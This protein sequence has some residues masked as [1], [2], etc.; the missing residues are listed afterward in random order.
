MNRR[1]VT[2]SG[3]ALALAL[4]APAAAPGGPATGAEDSYALKG[5]VYPT[6]FKIEMKNRAGRKLVSVKAGTYRI[7]VEDPSAIHNFR[8]KGPG[9]NRATT[10]TGKTERIW[11]VT[12]K[13]GIYKFLCDPHPTTMHGSF[14][15]T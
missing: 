2:A 10:V 5:E 4:L 3:T 15:V 13:K 1:L 11:T 6:A 12:L 8:L 9:V 14:R 7:K